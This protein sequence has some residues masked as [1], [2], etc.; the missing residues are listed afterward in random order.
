M[1]AYDG[2]DD[3]DDD[4]DE[5]F[6]TLAF[7]LKSTACISSMLTFEI[8]MPIERDFFSHFESRQFMLPQFSID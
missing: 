7:K 4:D 3:D 2:G 5:D 8:F 1:D 6:P